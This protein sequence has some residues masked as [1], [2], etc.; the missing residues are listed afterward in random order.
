MAARA[1]AARC[2]R[3][4]AVAAVDPTA[5]AGTAG[6]FAGYGVDVAVTLD[7]GP[8]PV[9]DARL[10]L[11]LLVAGWLRGQVG[12]AEIAGSAEITVEV[13]PVAPGSGAAHCRRLG[14]EL[15]RRLGSEDARTGLLVLGD[16][17]ATHTLRAPGYFDPRAE[18]L[19]RAVA[20]ALREADPDTLLGLDADLCDELLVAGR[21]A[22][23]V[24]TAAAQALA[25]AWHG[26]LLY[27]AAPFGV[28]YH[29]ALWEVARGEPAQEEPADAD[30]FAGPVP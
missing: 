17:A 14:T 4:V 29:V 1:L 30:P 18:A 2:A 5:A 22:W 26:Q 12:S 25:P 19:D 27:S 10:P 23:Q 24:G 15:G 3:W 11:P 6:S 8:A 21:E 9:A 28:A 20:R 7:P 16:G 13:F